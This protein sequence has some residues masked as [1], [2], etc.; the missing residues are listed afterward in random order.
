[1]L[2]LMLTIAMTIASCTIM[3]RVADAED[4]NGLAWG[5]I[6]LGLCFVCWL[7]VPWPLIDIGLALGIA[8]FSLFG[9]KVIWD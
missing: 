7:T 4:R 8:F 5:A 2:S 1:M 3:T 9:A 6:T